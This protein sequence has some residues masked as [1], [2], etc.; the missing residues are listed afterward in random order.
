M[1]TVAIRPTSELVALA[2]L[3]TLPGVTPGMVAATL[4]AVASW[5]DTGFYTVTGAGGVPEVDLPV[6]RPLVQVDCWASK[7]AAGRPPWGWADQLAQAV[8]D[9]CY[10]RLGNPVTL[11][12][13]AGSNT[14][15][16]RLLGAWA[17]SEP[18]RVYGDD[19]SY[20]RKRVDVRL[21]WTG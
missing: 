20:A 17:A 2:W 15:T 1:P 14:A 9:A 11:T 21:D 19:A 10:G 5:Q 7:A 3:R 16:A 13:T 6:R 8:I 4:P 12:V 18:Q